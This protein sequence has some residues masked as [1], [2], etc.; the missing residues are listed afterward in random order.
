MEEEDRPLER[1]RTRSEETVFEDAMDDESELINESIRQ[2]AEETNRTFE[3]P[4]IEERPFE[5]PQANQQQ[6]PR[7]YQVNTGEVKPN[8]QDNGDSSESWKN[9]LVPKYRLRFRRSRLGEEN[10]FHGR[11]LKEKTNDIERKMSVAS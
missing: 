1:L 2:D 10:H 8:V 4:L 6:R 7:G 5:R 9:H 11:L 3:S